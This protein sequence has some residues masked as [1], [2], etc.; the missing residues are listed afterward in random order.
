M[1]WQEVLTAEETYMI[2]VKSR[3][4]DLADHAEK[5]GHNDLSQIYAGAKSAY[6]KA[7]QSL[8]AMR[9]NIERLE[10]H[11]NQGKLPPE[12]QQFAGSASPHRKRVICKAFE[13][14][15]CIQSKPSD[16]FRQELRKESML[17]MQRVQALLLDKSISDADLEKYIEGIGEMLC[18]LEISE[19]AAKPEKKKAG[20]IKSL[21]PGALKMGAV[22]VATW[23]ARDIW[24]GRGK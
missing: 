1:F 24:E 17:F 5:T 18:G 12:I 7:M 4:L 16:V 11:G 8:Q 19:T 10:R 22:A 3:L 14:L 20:G 6:D 15:Q 2:T 23:K 21:V 9:V 13:V